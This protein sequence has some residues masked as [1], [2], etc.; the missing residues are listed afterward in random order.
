[1]NLTK[2]LKGIFDIQSLCT[3]DFIKDKC[4]SLI[5][6]ICNFIQ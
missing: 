3:G 4:K 1:M 5:F 2:F 6:N